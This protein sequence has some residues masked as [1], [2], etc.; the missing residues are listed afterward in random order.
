[1]GPS[2]LF[3]VEMPK[4]HEPVTLQEEIERLWSDQPGFLEEVEF[5]EARGKRFSFQK[6]HSSIEINWRGLQGDRAVG[7]LSE[8][9]TVTSVS[10]TGSNHTR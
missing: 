8:H 4:E 2:E 1:M 10:H 3:L 9:S 7:E 6:D 5:V